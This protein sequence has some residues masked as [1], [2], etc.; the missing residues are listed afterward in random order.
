GGVS[1]AGVAAAKSGRRAGAGGGGGGA[2]PAPA[3]GGRP[4][5]LFGAAGP[6]FDVTATNVHL[7]DRRAYERNVAAV[8]ALLGDER[9]EALAAEGAALSLEQAIAEALTP[10]AVEDAAYA[11]NGPVRPRLTR[12]EQEVAVLIARGLTNRQIGAALTISEGTVGTHVE[13]MLEKLGVQSRAQVAV[14]AVES[15][16]L[17]AAPLSP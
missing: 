13:H 3:G 12:R 9:F 11:T 10:E 1:P 5:R 14:W 8:R 6:F 16:L 2:P 7:T 15:G 4:P 17:R